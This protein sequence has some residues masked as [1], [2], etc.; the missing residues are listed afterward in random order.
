MIKKIITILAIIPTVCFAQ[1]TQLGN[2]INGTQAGEF[3]GS[4]HSVAID[5]SGNTIAVGTYRNHALFQNSGYAKVLDW[6]GSSWIQRGSDLVSIDT[7]HRGTG[8]AVD[9]NA[10]GMTVAVGSPYGY[11]SLGF[12]SGIVRVFDWSGSN[13]VQRGSTIEGEGNSN[14][15]FEFDLF[16]SALQLSDDGNHLVIGGNA[17]TA[18]VGANQ[19]GGHVRVF[20]WNGSA[21]NQIGQDIDALLSFGTQEF[22][23]A[24]SINNAGS[25]VAVGARAYTGTNAANS[26]MGLAMVLEFNGANW[27]ALGDTIFGGTSSNKLGSAVQLSGSGNTLVVG[28]P[29][30]NSFQGL[31]KIFDWNGTNWIQRGADIAGLLGGQ[32]GASIG[33]SSNG[34]IVAIGDPGA[35]SLKGATRIF[36]WNGNSWQQFGNTI[37]LSGN[38]MDSFG[39]AVR[40][41]HSGSRVVVGLPFNDQ[42]A[43]NAGQVRVYENSTL[44]GI[45]DLHFTKNLSV[46]P[47]PI[48]DIFQIRSDYAITGYELY[49]LSG[50]LIDFSEVNNLLTLEI[51]MFKLKEGTYILRVNTLEGITNLKLVKL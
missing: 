43:N 40:L 16:G 22:G 17:N 30:A 34:N 29:G 49:N 1:W 13:W 41:N 10:N 21:W 33:L 4:T 47:N 32:S 35:N 38:N 3:L 45:D 19:K 51:N 26:E 7:T 11:N 39:S 9:L 5:S 24:V 46:F 28:A 42:L 48:I 14:P 23:Y 20:Q 44:T 18:Q 31:T 6:N 27:V 37:S 12:R 50:Q 8:Y 36:N 15:L 25:R 2:S